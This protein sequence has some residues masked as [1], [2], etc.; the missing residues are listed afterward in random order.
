MVSRESAQ[1]I[2]GVYTQ[3]GLGV[4]GVLGDDLF[5]S[6]NSNICAVT[7]ILLLDKCLKNFKFCD[8]VHVDTDSVDSFAYYEIVSRFFG[9]FCHQNKA[10]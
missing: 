2:L 1:D 9:Y 4:V 3:T 8:H 7:A 5:R 6:E 10:F